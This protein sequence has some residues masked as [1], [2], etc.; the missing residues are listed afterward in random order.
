MQKRQH[1]FGWARSQSDQRLAKLAT[2]A[3]QRSSAFCYVQRSVWTFL[4]Q[5]LAAPIAS[6]GAAHSI[7]CL[8]GRPCLSPRTTTTHCLC[9]APLVIPPAVPYDVLKLSIVCL[10]PVPHTLLIYI[11]RMLDEHARRRA[12]RAA[13]P[14]ADLHCSSPCR[15]IHPAGAASRMFA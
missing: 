8:Q 11:V 1:I 4:C 2:C 3:G 5:H 15:A 9:F 13:F 7:A 10:I 14:I 6:Q 12:G